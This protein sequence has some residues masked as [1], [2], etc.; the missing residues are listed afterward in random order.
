MLTL[1]RCAFGIFA[2]MLQNGSVM[3]LGV[4]SPT[5][6]SRKSNLLSRRLHTKLS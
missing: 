5:P 6:S 4:I 2:V 3:M 1:N